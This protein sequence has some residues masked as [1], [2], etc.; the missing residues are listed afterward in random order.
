MLKEISEMNNKVNNLK[1]LQVIMGHFP[2][3]S[4]TKNMV[5]FDQYMKHG[6]FQ[7]FDYGERNNQK[8]YGQK[9]PPQYNLENIT[10]PVHMYVGKYDKL[11]DVEDCQNLFNNLKNSPGKTMKIYDFGHATFVWGLS[12]KHM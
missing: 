3:G 9:T 7:M 5:Q 10:F 4:S 6:K 1:R 8:H 2:S 11:A 12:L